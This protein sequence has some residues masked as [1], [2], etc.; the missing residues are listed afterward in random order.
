M[1]NKRHREGA[2]KTWAGFQRVGR[3]NERSE[4]EENV[5]KKDGD[6]KGEDVE[7]ML[8]ERLRRI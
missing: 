1:P 4:E 2:D 7:G 8:T 6:K 5:M 3:E